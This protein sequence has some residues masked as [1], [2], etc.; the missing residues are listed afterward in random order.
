[1]TP[2]SADVVVRM[3][4]QA[5]TGDQKA[6][7]KLMPLVYDELRRV[8]RGYMR[9]ERAGQTI[10]ATA[11]VHEA[12]LRLLKDKKQNWRDRTHFLA[13]AAIAM[14]QILVER[15]RARAAS[16]RGGSRARVTLHEALVAADR[17]PG[18]R[19]GARP[20]P[21]QAGRY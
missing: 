10:Q 17:T 14:R 5:R 21:R 4:Q 18:R 8:G 2:P 15:A 13:I 16:K 9:R 19:A 1:M 11:L 20:G 3:I 12:Y 7:S 6:I